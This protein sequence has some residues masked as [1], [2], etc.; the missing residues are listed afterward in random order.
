MALPFKQIVDADSQ[1]DH[2]RPR[3]VRPGSVWSVPPW[4]STR[5]YALGTP[6]ARAMITNARWWTSILLVDA[7]AELWNLLPSRFTLGDIA[8]VLRSIGIEINDTDSRTEVVAFL[9]SL[10]SEGLLRSEEA[11][12][13]EPDHRAAKAAFDGGAVLNSIEADFFDWLVDRGL[14]P[15][16]MIELTY[17]CNQRC[18]HCF[19]PGAAHAPGKQPRRNGSDLGTE[20]I[21]GL[22]RQLAES[23]VFVLTFSGGEP[24]LRPD[25]VPILQEARRLG[26]PF[27]VYT[28]GQLSADCLREI[29]ALW[30]RTVGISLYSSV[31][32]IHD[33]T[34][35]VKGSFQ[36]ALDSV[37]LVAGAGVRA[38][39]KCPLMRHTVFGYKKLLELCDEL[40]ALP[41]IDFHITA[42][43]DGDPACT[44]HQIL[45]EQALKSVMSDPHLG[46]HVGPE[47][48]NFGRRP[49]ALDGPVCGAGRYSL[50]IAP[51]GTVYPCN[52]LPLNLGNIRFSSL[53]E[54]RG[55]TA[56][57]AWRSVT[58]ADFDECGL[59]A[60]CAYCNHC[61]GMAM[62]EKGDLLAASKTC[63]VT[64]RARMNLSEEVRTAQAAT[65]AALP[66]FGRDSSIRM[67]VTSTQAPE[68]CNSICDPRRLSPEQI[69]ERIARIHEEGNT[70]R[71]K[72]IPQSG[73]PA[74]ENI[75]EAD[76]ERRDRFREFG[77]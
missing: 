13:P 43:M 19:N 16:A 53:A 72:K 47:V 2:G 18:V 75:K 15:T 9:E 76:V 26:F 25:L 60:H 55:G 39:V 54:I 40:N 51:D 21:H 67:P 46:M 29:C 32:E 66:G 10:H 38:T 36:R 24:S 48:P 58:L 12:N 71:K 45:D 7:S 56:L 74:A 70:R 69:A 68:P 57:A 22:L 4:V 8:A 65:I 44:V 31:A 59:Y 23:G 20:D 49:R 1:A 64:A 52:G 30:P 14:L 35:G 5:C 11:G 61:P 63:C 6:S 37:R 41:Q 3:S 62:A 17:R 42:G 34:T 28:N 27:D 77:R 50:S 33:A 73:S